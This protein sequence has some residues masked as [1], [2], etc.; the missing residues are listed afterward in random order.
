MKVWRWPLGDGMTNGTETRCEC[1]ACIKEF[2]ITAGGQ[3]IFGSLPLSSTKMI[4]C[5]KCGNKRC[6]KASDH[7]LECTGSNVPGQPGSIYYKS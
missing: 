2:N 5:P 1:H 6:P 3:G 7:R 4:L